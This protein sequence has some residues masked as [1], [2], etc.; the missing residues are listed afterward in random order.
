[1][2]LAPFWGSSN[3]RVSVP[4]ALRP[5][6]FAAVGIRP[7]V[8]V[9]S[10]ESAAESVGLCDGCASCGSGGAPPRRGDVNGRA[11]PRP[12]VAMFTSAPLAPSAGSC[13]CVG[14]T[15]SVVSLSRTRARLPGV[16]FPT[17][18]CL[19]LPLR[20]F[21]EHGS[22]SLRLVALLLSSASR[23]ISKDAAAHGRPV[24]C[25]GAPAGGRSPPR[26]RRVCRRYFAPRAAGRLGAFSGAPGKDPVLFWDHFQE[27]RED[28]RSSRNRWP[29]HRFFLP[30]LRGLQLAGWRSCG[31][32]APARRRVVASG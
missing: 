6:R 5:A 28:S 32:P 25:L 1:M 4:F 31:V 30:R 12:V 26:R 8:A 15:L 22:V 7:W 2:F 14:N 23:L 17:A 24:R 20:L 21:L 9:L 19:R 18:P 3:F 16:R 13:Q 11:L 29:P 27:K 10:P